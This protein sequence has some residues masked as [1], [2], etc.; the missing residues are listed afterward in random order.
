[1][2]VSNGRRQQGV[3]IQT[4]F[5][6][7]EYMGAVEPGSA[8]LV[9]TDPPYGKDW[10]PYWGD[11]GKCA[12]RWLAPGGLL[13]AYSGKIYLKQVMD[14]LSE[15]LT[16]QWM[17]SSYEGAVGSVYRNRQVSGFW[18]PILVYSNGGWKDRDNWADVLC[19]PI[20]KSLH[21]WQQPIADAKK[22]IEY[23]SSPGDLVIDPCAGSFT[24]AEAAQ[25][26]GRRFVACDE[27][28]ACITLGQER[29]KL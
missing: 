4:K 26:L 12:A 17:I 28:E 19:S 29:L 13:V 20:E 5:Q 3:I 22:L 21:A 8:Q 7:L 11:L 9:L 27:S 25:S 18:K 14:W 1:M 16:Y 24:V 10:L 6:N 15:H 23:F 2:P